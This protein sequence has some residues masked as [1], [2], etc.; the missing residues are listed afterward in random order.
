MNFDDVIKGRRSIRG[1]KQK[2]VTKKVLESILELAI[3]SP[4]SMNT[5]PW[6][7]HIVTGKVLDSI[8]KENTEKNIL[9]LELGTL[10]QQKEKNLNLYLMYLK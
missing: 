5:Q 1:F 7:F 4:S 8:R 10:K 2:P 3:R 9:V 6:H